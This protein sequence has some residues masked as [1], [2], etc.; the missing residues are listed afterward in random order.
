MENQPDGNIIATQ[1]DI[2]GNES[3]PETV[4]FDDVTAPDAPASSITENP[5]G[6]LSVSGMGEPGAEVEVTF[7]DGTMGTATV[8]ADGTYGPITSVDPQAAGDVVTTQTDIAGNESTSTTESFHE[9]TIDTVNASTIT[10]TT[11]P[12]SSVAIDVDS[13]GEVD[14][15]VIADASGN[16]TADISGYTTTPQAF[17]SGYDPISS[18]GEAAGEFI[19]I[20]WS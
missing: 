9:V 16:Y 7:P 14:T 20:T 6:T 11:L 19:E 18:N 1:T 4:A 3:D 13:D 15:T 12:N 10:G 5:S 2:A 17:I 8:A